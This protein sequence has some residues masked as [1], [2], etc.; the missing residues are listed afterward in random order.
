MVSGVMSRLLETRKRGCVWEDASSDPTMKNRKNLPTLTAVRPS[1]S[2]AL[3]PPPCLLVMLK[4][5]L[6]LGEGRTMALIGLWGMWFPGE[7][8]GELAMMGK[9]ERKRL[10]LSERRRSV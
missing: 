4:R 5:L 8:G 3:L 10:S 6:L 9:K 7:A 2:E 1:S